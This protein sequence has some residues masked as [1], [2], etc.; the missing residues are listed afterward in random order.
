MPLQKHRCILLLDIKSKCFFLFHFMRLSL[1]DCKQNMSPLGLIENYFHTAAWNILPRA[2]C[3]IAVCFCQ[4]VVFCRLLLD[5]SVETRECNKP[6]QK[7]KKKETG[8]DCGCLSMLVFLSKAK[9][10]DIKLFFKKYFYIT[11]S[12]IARLSTSTTLLQ[13]KT[14]CGLPCELHF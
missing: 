5:N 14:C 11:F 6:L 3:E 9:M 4:N 12:L 10:F 7:K 2:A 8:R 1:P 13:P